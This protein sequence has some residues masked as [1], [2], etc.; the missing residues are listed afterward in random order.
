MVKQELYAL[1]I[2][3]NAIKIRVGW[4]EDLQTGEFSLGFFKDFKALTGMVYDDECKILFPP[5]K[6][7]RHTKPV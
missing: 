5:Q 2:T 1:V 4:K 6:V 3:A 7:N